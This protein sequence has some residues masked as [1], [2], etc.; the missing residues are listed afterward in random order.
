VQIDTMAMTYRITYLASPVPATTGTVTPTRSSPPG[1]TASGTLSRETLLPT[2]KLNRCT[3]RLENASL[4][5]ARPARIFF[6]DGMLGGAIPGAEIAF[7]GV[8]GVGVV[9]NARFPYYPFIA[10]AEQSTSL[11]EIAGTYSMLGYHKIP[12]QNFLPVAVD[13]SLTIRADGSFVECDSNGVHAGQCRQP[14]T[15]FALRNDSPAFESGRFFGQAAPTQAVD[16][17]QARGI[18]IV[19]KLRR[20]LV[21]VLV[22]VG[23]AD[24]SIH[25]PPGA[26]PKTPLADD[27]SGI[28]LL[29]PQAPVRAGSQNG[30]YVGVDSNFAYRAMALVGTQS[31]LLDP[32]NPSQASLAAAL[33]LDYSRATWGVVA[34]KSAKGFGDGASTGKIIFAGGAFGYLD[35]T[36]PSAPYFAMGAFSQ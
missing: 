19:G 10:F 7:A 3:F 35:E 11:T 17:P 33:D 8:A 1:N 5:P 14:G 12:S 21:P 26:A 22:R 28:A 34:V 18:L 30:E 2:E 25:A 23:A 20:Q 13:A 9:P 16:G 29:A 24:P 15:N 4:D 27:E 32:F 36:N 31:T 6:G